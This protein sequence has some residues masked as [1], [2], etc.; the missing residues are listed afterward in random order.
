MPLDLTSYVGAS[1]GPPFPAP[2]AVN[3]AMIRHWCE[4]MGDGNLRYAG[5]TEA[6]PTMLLAWTMPGFGKTPAPRLGTQGELMAKLDA[7]GFT[8]VVATDTEE[9]YV[10][11]LRPGDHVTATTIIENV[12][13][14]KKTGLG[15]GHFVTTATTFTAAEGEVVGRATFRI[16]KFEPP[17]KTDPAPPRPRPPVNRDNQFF[18]DGTLENELRI[19]RCTSCQALRHPPGPMCPRCRSLSWDYIVASGRGTVYSHV[20]HHYP[21]MP[22]FG[23]PHNVVLVDLEEGVR[24]VSNLLDESAEIV[25][26]MPVQLVFTKVADD[27]VLPQFQARRPG[28]AERQFGVAE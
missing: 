21:P 19:Q 13:D 6:P 15:V 1:A 2:V 20:R 26:G 10:R 28:E 24:F 16:L 12:S 27:Y 25:I 11:Y 5:G 18:W 22:Q 9:E 23:S 14:E 4:A 3:E 7:A 8:S 17:P